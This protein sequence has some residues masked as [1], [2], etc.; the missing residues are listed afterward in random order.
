VVAKSAKFHTCSPTT[1]S[2]RSNTRWFI[3]RYS[4]W[5]SSVHGC[6]ATPW[7]PGQGV[8]AVLDDDARLALGRPA[9]QL[10]LQRG[11]GVVG[12]L[13]I[14]HNTTEG[15]FLSRAMSSRMAWSCTARVSSLIVSSL[16]VW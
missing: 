14:D 13:A 7:S 1:A 12:S 5:Y 8:G 11:L 4:T 3:A 15:W 6:A 10:V 2:T 9:P 16:K